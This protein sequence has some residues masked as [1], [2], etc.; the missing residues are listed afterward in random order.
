MRI[1]AYRK[2]PK[3][4]MAWTQLDFWTTPEGL[5][6]IEEWSLAGASRR[7]LII[8]I[9]ITQEKFYSW[10]KKSPEFSAA[11]NRYM[12]LVTSR[13]E[14]ALYKRAVGYETVEKTKELRYDEETGQERMML[15]KAVKKEVAPDVSAAKFW[16]TNVAGE[17]WKEKQETRI[18]ID[19]PVIL[20]GVDE[21]ME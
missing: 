1:V 16:L 5:A 18:E 15:T 9:G 7:S 12:D 20:S 21:V 17:D 10:C 6:Q 2:T 4:T 13:V 3:R 19:G 8:Q 14:D 11:V